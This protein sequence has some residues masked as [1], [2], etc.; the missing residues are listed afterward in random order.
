MTAVV[1]VEIRDLELVL[2]RIE[3][4]ITLTPDEKN[5]AR[6]LRERV[7]SPGQDAVREAAGRLFDEKFRAAGWT[8]DDLHSFSAFCLRKGAAAIAAGGETAGMQQI[9]SAYFL[10]GAIPQLDP[11]TGQMTSPLLDR[12]MAVINEAREQVTS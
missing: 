12:C 7:M 5:A 8:E 9:I 11:E 3:Q 10:A 2:P 4:Q 1:Q 6:R